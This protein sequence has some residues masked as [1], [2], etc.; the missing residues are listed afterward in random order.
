MLPT[1]KKNPQSTQPMQ[2][3]LSLSDRRTIGLLFNKMRRRTKRWPALDD[4]CLGGLGFTK[5][6]MFIYREKKGRSKYLLASPTNQ[7][8]KAAPSL[9]PSSC[10]RIP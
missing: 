6:K 7:L 9:N 1:P 10:L 2:V 3:K 4:K 5:K 8:Q